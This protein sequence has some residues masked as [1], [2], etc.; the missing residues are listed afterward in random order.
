[1]TVFRFPFFNL[2]L[3]PHQEKKKFSPLPLARLSL[4]AA[5]K[6]SS[7]QLHL[8]SIFY[9]SGKEVETLFA[10]Q[11]KNKRR[12]ENAAEPGKTK[13]KKPLSLS[14]TYFF[15]ALFPTPR[16][17]RSCVTTLGRLVLIVV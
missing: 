6:Q 9:L 12:K 10:L 1:V 16:V 8:Q 15:L 3:F 11:R 13:N 2:D 5:P 7:L 14:P 4:A 17:S